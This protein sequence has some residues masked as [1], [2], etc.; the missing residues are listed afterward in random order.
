[1]FVFSN[2]PISAKV[3]LSRL[4]WQFPGMES[5]RCGTDIWWCVQ[6]KFLGDNVHVPNLQAACHRFPF[7]S[8]VSS[9]TFAPT[10]TFP[11][12]RAA[13]CSAALWLCDS[14]SSWHHSLCYLFTTV[15]QILALISP[16]FSSLNTKELQSQLLSQVNNHIF[17]SL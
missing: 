2:D 16:V 12:H 17:F 7:A 4:L 5:S 1:M 8:H 6:Y 11:L 9:C 10:W 3:T 13:L 14:C 15:P